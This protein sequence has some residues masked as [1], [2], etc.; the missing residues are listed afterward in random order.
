MKKFSFVILV[1]SCFLL[2]SACTSSE[3]E[4]TDKVKIGASPTPHAEILEHIKPELKKKGIDLEIVKFD[5]YVLP[6]K[7]LENG[8]I[9]A[10]Y[11]STVPYFNL[12]KKENGYKF[13]NIGAIH[14]EPMG[15]YSHKIK[16]VSEIPNGAKVIVSNVPSE[17]GRVLNIFVKNKLIKIKSGIAIDKANFDD[18]TE[19]PKNLVFEHS[20]DPTLLTS[21][22]ENNEGDLVAINSNFAYEKGLNPVKDSLMIEQNDS[23]YVNIVAVKSSD[24]NNEDLKKIVEVLH[25]PKVQ[26]WIEKKWGGSIVPV[27]E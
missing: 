13:S 23:P 4:K 18:I 15:I 1:L 2:L 20:V 17:W 27:N 12:Q 3:A 6:N 8:D 22:Y 19:N 21:A 5:D 26:K 24:K 14:L 25:E 7:A 10:N 16:K 11:F 9:D